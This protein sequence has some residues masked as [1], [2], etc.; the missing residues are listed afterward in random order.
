M[1]IKYMICPLVIYEDFIKYHN[2]KLKIHIWY[3][4]I[5]AITAII[6]L[7]INYILMTEIIQYY[8]EVDVYEKM[9][10]PELFLKITPLVFF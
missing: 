3:L 5:K 9:S 6:C 8:L 7:L 1:K 10:S 2:E 4:I